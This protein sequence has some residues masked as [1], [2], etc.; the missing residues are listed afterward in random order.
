[1]QSFEQIHTDKAPA[2]LGPYSQAVRAGNL[3]LLSGQIP[4]DP[5]KGEIVSSDIRMQ[6]TQVMENLKA[7]LSASGLDFTNVVKADIFITSMKDF[8]VINE[9]Y[10]SYFAG[11]YKP[12]R[13]TIEVSAL[14]KGASVEISFIAAEH[15]AK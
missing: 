3:L 14:P 12:A 6:T 7:V 8:P 5:Q 1:M 15:T 9:V 13:Q 4:M 11:D 2:A 10:G